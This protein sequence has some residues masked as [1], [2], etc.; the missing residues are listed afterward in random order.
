[1]CY[2]PSEAGDVAPELRLRG[3]NVLCLV[4]VTNPQLGLINAPPPYLFP[5]HNDLF[6]YSFTIKKARN[7]LNAGE[8]GMC[9]VWCMLLCYVLLAYSYVYIYIYIYICVVMF[10]IRI[11][12]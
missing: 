5:P 2:T 9:Y 1:M 8:D 6:Q 3:R 7:R 10:A 12:I 11:R 4:Y